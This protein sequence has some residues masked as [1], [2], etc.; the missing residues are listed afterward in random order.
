MF[1]GVVVVVVLATVV[2]ACSGSDSE[3]SSTTTSSTTRPAPGGT[4]TGDGTLALGQLAP[5]S[6]RLSSISQ[7][8]TAPVQIAVDE[9]NAAGG[10][11][12]KPV[13]LKVADD[14]GGENEDVAN[15]ALDGLLRGQK[16]DAIIGPTATGTA[17]DQLETV[18]DAGAIECSG[19]NSAEELSDSSA[20]GAYFRT[21]PPDRLQALALARLVG[22]SGRKRPVIVARNDAYGATFTNRVRRELAKQKIATAGPVITYDPGAADLTAVAEKVKARKADSVVAISLTEDGARLVKAL[23]AQ[24]I[25][26]G[27]LPL[28]A[29]D[30]MQ[31]TTFHTSVDAANPA[32]VKGIVGTAPAAAPATPE[33]AFTA[34]MRR[35]G[36]APIFSAYYYDCTVLMALAAQQ[37][38]T[39]NGVKMRRTFAKSLAGATDCTSY[40]ECKRALQL[41]KT[42]H[43]RGASSRF[44]RW[45][46]NEPGQGSYDVWSYG[47]DGAVVTGP[48]TQQIAVP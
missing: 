31:S 11:N 41:G 4:G 8:L 39:D 23:T 24:G 20:T 27:A 17:L 33:N 46:G 21:A 37:A 6:G 25:G 22:T 5:L 30:G 44:D 34:A 12:G 28:F 16:V 3:G 18:R 19:S 38:K 43:Y 29:P 48:P 10:V 42:I 7:S 1:Q 45:D 15:K 32:A 40:A 14:G 35:A 2:A 9:I 47:P 36:V 13:T 26:P